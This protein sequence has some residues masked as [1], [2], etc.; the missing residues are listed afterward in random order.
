MT[1]FFADKTGEEGGRCIFKKKEVSGQ[2]IQE[3]F[4]KV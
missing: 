4:G 3:M 1:L 2:K